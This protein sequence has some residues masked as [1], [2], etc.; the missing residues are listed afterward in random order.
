[1]A[2]LF[3][4]LGTAW[5]QIPTAST[6]P[7]DGQW[8]ADTKWYTIKVNDDGGGYVSLYYSDCGSNLLLNNNTQ[9]GA[10]GLWCVV[11]NETDGYSFYNAITGASKVLGATGREDGGRMKM[12]DAS[13]PGNGVTT[14]FDIRKLDGQDGYAFVRN[15]GDNNDYWNHRGNYLAY[16]NNSAAY[17][18]GCTG[19]Q[20]VFTEVTSLADYASNSKTAILEA[21]TNFAQLGN[22]VD[23]T[24]AS[25]A[26]ATVEANE[27]TDA[28]AIT[29]MYAELQK[30]ISAIESTNY[31][32]RNSDTGNSNRIDAYL[33]TRAN[34]E[35][36][37]GTNDKTKWGNI[38]WSLKYASGKN[39]YLYNTI[40]DRYLGNPEGQGVLGTAT[41]ATYSFTVVDAAANKVKLTCGNQTLHLNNHNDGF[42]SNYDNSDAASQWYIENDLTGRVPEYKAAMAPLLTQAKELAQDSRL[43]SSTELA[44]LNA[45]IN[46]V[47]SAETDFVAL[48]N[49]IAA[50]PALM[51]ACEDY[52]RESN[53]S[54]ITALNYTE[55][56]N[57]PVIV[58]NKRSNWGVANNATGLNTLAK[59]GFAQSEM[60][61]KQQFA[62]I[63]PDGGKNYYLYSI[64]AQRYLKSNNTFAAQGEPVAFADASSEG[65]NRVQVRFRDVAQ[66]FINVGGSKQLAI[67]WWNEIDE[68][69]ACE[70]V[71]YNTLEFD[72]DYALKVF[73]EGAEVTVKYMLGEDQVLL[74]SEF[75]F[76][77]NTKTIS[78]NWAKITSVTVNGTPMAAPGG[79]ADWVYTVDVAGPKEI[80]VNLEL[81]D[82]VY[83]LQSPASP[84]TYFNF[85]PVTV[86]GNETK[87]T[88]QS[89]PSYLYIIP[90]E[91]AHILKS[92]DDETVFVGST[93]G[94]C[95]TADQSLWNISE[96]DAN[97]L[98]SITRKDDANKRLGS[99]SDTNAGTAIFTNVG[100]NCNKWKIA[101]AY[102]LTVIYKLGD[103]EESRIETFVDAGSE[104][105]I[106]KNSV[107][108]NRLITSCK[109]GE[110]PVTNIDG[111]YT[112][113]VNAATTITVTMQEIEETNLYALQS[114][115]GTYF[116]FTTVVPAANNPATY[117]SFQNTPSFLFRE[118]S[119]ESYYFED[120]NNPG[121]YIGE[122]PS[123]TNWIVSKSNKTLWNISAPDGD[124]FVTISRSA[125]AAKRLGHDTQWSAGTG[126]FTNV[127]SGCNKWQ[128]IPAYP[129]TI[130][131]KYNE[132]EVHREKTAVL[133]GEY[134]DID[135]QNWDV[136]SCT[137]NKGEIVEE[138]WYYI[139]A[140]YGA[141]EVTVTLQSY[142]KYSTSKPEF[143]DETGDI[144]GNNQ[145]L[146]ALALDGTI[147]ITG[148]TAP[149]SVTDMYVLLPEDVVA[150]TRGEH[151]FT[152]TFPDGNPSKG[153]AVTLWLDKGGDG[154]FETSLGTTGNANQNNSL[155]T[156]TFTIPDDAVLG[157]TR[158]RFRLDSAWGIAA[159]ADAA[160]NR[161]VYD[162][163]VVI[164]DEVVKKTLTYN[165]IY[166]GNKIASQEL[167]ASVGTS[168]PVPTQQFKVASEL[169]SFVLP[170][171]KVEAGTD[172]YNVEVRINKADFPTPTT[173]TDGQFANDTQ[174][175]FA[176]LR[177]EYMQYNGSTEV[178]TT[179]AHGLTDSDL[180]TVVGNPADGYHIY[181]KALGV[182]KAIYSNTPNG[183]SSAVELNT[184][185]NGSWYVTTNSNGGFSFYN[186]NNSTNH[187]LHEKNDRLMHWSD[188]KS[189]TDAGSSLIFKPAY[190]YTVLIGEVP[191]EV[192]AEAKYRGTTTLTNNG[193][194]L[195]PNVDL[196]LFT[197]K[198]IS[199]NTWKYIVDEEKKTISLAYTAVVPEVNPEAVVN[200]LARVG[201]WD[202]VDK[203]KFVLDP[204]INSKQETFIIGSENGK[205]L[206]KG[207]TL[208]ALTTGLGW[209]L[210]N[211]AHINI[212]WN[213][214]NEKTVSGAAYA[215][216]SDI[217][218]PTT[219]ETHTSDAKYRYYLNTCTFGYSMTSWTWKRWQ[220]EIDWMA[221]HGIN[222][223]LQLVGLE[224]VWR[225]FLTMEDGN[226]RR[227]Y[228]YTDEAAK[229]F[230]AG[231]A[232]IA[233]WA[234]N[235]LEGWGGTAAG[236]KSGYNNLAG[237]GGVQDDAWYARQKE[238]AGKIV[239]AQRAL[240]MQP[241]IPGWSGMVPT[242]F[243]SKSKYATRGNGGNW[244]GDFVRPLLLSVNNK[245]Y[246]EIAAD[247]YECLHAVM[248]ESQYYS[249]D[250]FHEGGGAG[251]M[252]DYEALYAAMEA[253][254]KGSQWVIQQWQ[255][256]ATQKYSLTAVPEGR[257]IVLDLFS[258]GKP[259]FDSYNGYTP[260]DAVFCA[261]PNFGGRSGL[262][263]RLQNL[264]D[265]Y[266]KFK[267][268]YAS[269]KGIGAAPEAIEQTPVTYDLIFQLPWMNGVKPDVAAWV[270]NYAYARYGKNNSVVKEA[271]S[272]LRQGPLNYGADG[273]QGPVE[274]VWAARPNLNA[275]PASAWGKTLNDA[276]GTYNKERHQMLIDAVYKLIDQEDE[277]ALVDGSTYKSN[278]LYDLVEFGGAV[279][280]DYAYYLLKGI[281]AAKGVDE[282][283][284]Q[285]RKNAFLQLILDMD[286]FRGTNLNFRLGKWT[287]EARDAAGE[288]EGATTADEDWY[289]YNN[290]RTILTTWS[291][292]GT[293]LNDYSYRSWQG[294]LK[295]FYY[296]RWKHYFDNDCTSAEYKY[297]EWN[298]A[299]GMTHNVGDAAI[300][301]TELTVGQD[302]HTDSYTREPVGNTIEEANEMLGKYIIPVVKADGEVYYAYRYLTNDEMASKVA[303]MATAGGTLNLTEIF[304]TDLTG[305]T[306]SGD[307]ATMV[308]DNTFADFSNVAIKADA[309]TGSHAGVITL[310]D[311]T[312]LKFNVVL[313]KYNGTYYIKYQD[314][315]TFIQKTDITDNGKL[316]GLYKLLGKGTGSEPAELD[317]IFTITPAGAGYTLSVQGKYIQSM[318]T[319][320]WRHLVFSDN[321][322]EAGVYIFNEAEGLVTFSSP[323]SN[324]N[325]ANYVGHYY[326]T[327]FGNDNTA[328]KFTITEV[329]S[330]AVTFADTLGTICF[331]FHVVIPAG[332]KAYD[333]TSDKLNYG[334]GSASAYAVLQLIATEGEVLKAGTPAVVK[335]EA[336]TY[337]FEIR[338]NGNGAK[339]S[340]D[341]SILKGNF[342]KESLATSNEHKKFVLGG[343]DF[344]AI[345]SATDIAANSCWIQTNINVENIQL[346][347]LNEKGEFE[348]SIVVVDDWLFKYE[349]VTNGIKLTDVALNGTGE[350]EIG[351]QY[352][353]DGKSRNVVAIA[354]DFMHGNKELTSVTFPSTLVNLGFQ[355]LE[356]M[357]EGRYEG[358]PGD[359]VNDNGNQGKN[360]CY[361]FPED[362]NTGKPYVVTQSGAWKLT[363]DVTIDTTKN[364]SF[365][366]FGSAIVSTHENSLADNYKG[367][368]QIYMWKNLQDIVVKIDNA[369]D[370]YKYSSVTLDANGDTIKA[371]NGSDSIL[372]NTKFRFELEHDGSGGYQVVIYYMNGKAKMYNISASEGNLVNNFDRLYYSLPE[373]IHVDVKF[374]R[375]LSKGLFVG[376]TNLTEIK[377]D[378][379][380]PVFKSCE[381]GVLYDKNGYYVMRIPEGGT[382]HYEIPSK[383][384]RLYAGAVHGV[385]ADVVLHSNPQI[386]VVV[387]HEEDVKYVNF[388]LSL[389]DIDNTITENETGHGGARDFISTNN[390]TYQAARYKRAPLADGKYGTIC[391]P[392]VPENAMEKY[393]FY[394]FKSGDGDNLTFSQV[395]VLEVNTPYLYRQKENPTETSDLE[396]DEV[397]GTDESELDV[398]ETTKSFQVETH[399]K[400]DPT[401]E[402]AGKSRALGSYV[403]FYIDTEA[404]HKK[405]G[406]YYYYYSVS[407]KKFLKVTELL[408]YRPYRAFFVVTPEEES[409]VAN[410]PARLNLIIE[411]A[412]GG[413]TEIDP[414]QIEGWEEDVYYDLMGRRVLNPT[415]GIYI[416]NGKK[417]VIE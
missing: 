164:V 75:L 22:L 60:D 196:D 412:N 260:Q 335:M 297:F 102:P 398:F 53:K 280:A 406:S 275:N 322:A 241:V 19:S 224:E 213:S 396:G 168:L 55:N 413:T 194:L 98:V 189:K 348:D 404:A 288:V 299:H 378:P 42:L 365:N 146:S 211:I 416:V 249:M 29:A 372:V 17:N 302:G 139:P 233:W 106:D 311:G 166:N 8:N 133:A 265:N 362:P 121:E 95:V 240:G 147:I 334:A 394:R 337:T 73:N 76:V 157:S 169:L 366:E 244:A 130:I 215:D 148:A 27:G 411:K 381:H 142:D 30:V 38:V 197:A 111:V 6:A 292:P 125:D 326:G 129:I 34:L 319:S 214:L 100:A 124:G 235:N 332:M 23:A 286:A 209:Y 237:A 252:E 331:P 61:T 128:L 291:S 243:A 287:Q 36:G 232:F 272:L 119:G 303:I 355:D 330:F 290:A 107:A 408:S 270:D 386:G 58:N 59:L 220:Q 212:A 266:F 103:V 231:P 35:K 217:P 375:L 340:K 263:G 67:D 324:S 80:V 176:T 238:L 229:A 206:I 160:A 403:N 323:V 415:N 167:T 70:I 5:A 46:A 187:Y 138:G 242:N 363:L 117:A 89:S 328:D 312:V 346:S 20:Y 399:A 221:L 201:G 50:L 37:H 11:G 156:I 77:G 177:N 409:Q 234:M 295:D 7:A 40:H 33:A 314:T 188:D 172:A 151:T 321:K 327:V 140:V 279:M 144:K 339:I 4:V 114:P 78:N 276:I 371:A 24:L 87:A 45:G 149:A 360:T 274:D 278:Y 97:G 407:Q 200:L 153:L 52:I 204:S 329:N 82:C 261:I 182:T 344:T 389:D 304:K 216:L 383:V 68:G 21:L 388:Y 208:S 380:N 105:T 253:A 268:Q 251:T 14:V 283:L 158:I 136:A 259:A 225:T 318:V 308:T 66:K 122:G 71:Q 145:Y 165:F 184:N 10:D 171:G 219:E 342:V 350:L 31:A 285:A 347:K 150:L 385:K 282:N 86:Q 239:E 181:N 39:F 163:P 377:V 267:G 108:Q 51:E 112:L 109:V 325:G 110:T 183:F 13:A 256:S 186:V 134:Y 12:Y 132:K 294:L 54:Y 44:N 3:L 115:T 32:F 245:K 94:W 92:K 376:C 41:T 116:N 81:E 210:N 400:Y 273:I 72:L 254:N 161:M 91:N 93:H 193:K 354:P 393:D 18:T 228:G 300:S 310:T 359:G 96:V 305:A 185:P 333:I 226:G 28:Q 85:T 222:M 141:T 405:N 250:P 264:T 79:N 101:K 69:N 284:Y 26:K 320:N 271:W 135:T 417:V 392:F 379:A 127:G 293:N 174:W 257:L 199:G 401:E 298:W 384:V 65:A 349:E 120:F 74:Q 345:K 368:M 269:I 246:A 16:W 277:L 170:E 25:Q 47:E 307:F 113:T 352:T 382:D 227:K 56:S 414:S 190:E 306:V 258:D 336:G 370:R 410:A 198:D 155:S 88:F 309:T 83:A 289:E 191:G 180:F 143:T 315:P 1:M 374:E 178:V 351:S 63:T 338:N 131:Y 357:F 353:V 154:I 2:S 9:P 313:A 175:Y 395:D 247:Y 195:L 341:G 159:T 152:L 390:N 218:V 230:V 15:H 387:G 202:V 296:K 391:L 162:I 236:S 317:K 316:T 262:M 123:G 373:G 301:S 364:A 402:K 281:A 49:D 361:V 369:D 57:H 255:W 62:F 367:Y 126:I 137:T 173:I 192:D 64:H 90:S 84:A 99:D 203:F 48:I 343:A 207:S 223:P 397:F 248:G 356:L 104:Y 205:I 118:L 43:A 179:S 358:K